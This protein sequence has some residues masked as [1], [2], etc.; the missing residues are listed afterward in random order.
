MSQLHRPHGSLWTGI[1]LAALFL[2][3][4]APAAYVITSS[5]QRID[6]TDIR[7]K[8]DGEIILT[9]AQGTRSFYQGQYLR[10]VADKPAEI[11]KAAQMAEAKQYDEAIKLLED[12]AVRYRFLDWDVQARVALPKV[13]LLK[14]DA[15]GAVTAYERL[16][17]SSPKTKEDQEVQWSYRQALLGAKQYDRLE[18]VLKDVIAK[19]SRGDAARAQIMRGDIK[20]AQ[21]QVEAAALDYMRTVILFASERSVQPE[22]LMKA[23]ESFEKLRDSRA[24][25]IYKKIVDEF[26]TSSQAT[27]A[28]AK[29]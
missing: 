28:R 17:T 14:G 23:A 12:V 1:F 20:A 8:S 9:T 16:F 6:G 18:T 2:A 5:N 15:A 7:A 22:A 19:G 11:D 25:D 27:A 24:K 3:G 4:S 10:A 13:Y 29:I 26:P 21:N